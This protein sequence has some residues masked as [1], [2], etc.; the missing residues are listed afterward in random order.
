MQAGNFLTLLQARGARVS[1]TDSQ[2]RRTVLLCSKKEKRKLFLPFF[3][4]SFFGQAILVFSKFHRFSRI[5]FKEKTLL[6][7]SRRRLGCRGSTAPALE[8]CAILGVS[9]GRARSHS[10]LAIVKRLKARR[11][12]PGVFQILASRFFR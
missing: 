2:A 4:C 12:Q 8:D 1:S 7:G 6:W 5:F 11:L 10:W 3:G 9:S